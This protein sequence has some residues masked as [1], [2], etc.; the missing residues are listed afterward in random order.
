MKS[1]N[2][3]CIVQTHNFPCHLVCGIKYK[4]EFHLRFVVKKTNDVF[5]LGKCL[6]SGEAVFYLTKTRDRFN[7]IHWPEYNVLTG[8]PV[9]ML[10]DISKQETYV[11]NFES[12]F[13]LYQQTLK[14]R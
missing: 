11:L 5:R 10:K 13:T 12:F 1:D 14:D 8:I 3:G 7:P 6:A 4:I 2:C 9:F